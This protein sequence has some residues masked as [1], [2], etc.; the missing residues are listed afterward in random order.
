MIGHA[1]DEKTIGSGD[2]DRTSSGE[3]QGRVLL[4]VKSPPEE[5]A[6]GYFYDRL[7]P[8]CL[9]GLWRDVA[10]STT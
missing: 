8:G 6:D 1:G 5:K 9:H 7:Q 3:K 4:R 2:P 10:S